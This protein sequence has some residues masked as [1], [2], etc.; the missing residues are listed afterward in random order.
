MLQDIAR[1]SRPRS[2]IIRGHDTN[3]TIRSDGVDG[4]KHGRP[5]RHDV[6]DNQH[7][8]RRRCANSQGSG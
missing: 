7:A 3:N 4:R 8:A 1:E 5:G 2:R 6:I